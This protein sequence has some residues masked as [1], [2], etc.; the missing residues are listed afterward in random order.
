[1]LP[2]EGIGPDIVARSLELLDRVAALGGRRFEVVRGGPI[3][4][5][6]VRQSGRALTPAVTD[7]CRDVLG[8]GGAVLAGAG[9]DR[10]VYELRRELDLFYK[11]NPIVVFPELADMRPVRVSDPALTDI[12][13]VR[14]NRAGLYQGRAR[15]SEDP[16][17]GRIVQ[18]FGYA[19]G[20]VREL[21]EVAA[22]YAVARENRLAVVAKRSGLPEITALWFEEAE[23]VAAT[24][25]LS[26]ELFD[27]DF[28]AYEFLAHPGR[29]DV[30]AVPNC[31]GDILADLG[32]LLMG[33]RGTTYG[34]SFGRKGGGVFQTNHGACH[35]LAGRDLANPA[36]Q[37]LSLAQLLQHTFRA[38]TEAAWI[39][40]AIRSVWAA[41]VRTADVAR[42]GT[43]PVGTAAFTAAVLD[44][45]DREAS[46]PASR[47][48]ASP[49]R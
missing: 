21:L 16:G 46:N 1:M 2:G 31:F 6:A 22:R 5:E 37:F 47:E 25:K 14:D 9:G 44:A 45:I 26:L 35:D 11:L 13:V 33:S 19:A 27:M 48:A 29:F 12:L 43:R 40:R 39:E 20:E 32:G 24:Y 10:F 7:F 38:E 28:A 30:V 15:R 34:A 8:R 3:G 42:P 41:G 4:C 17:G 18:E 36:G 23:K 49:A